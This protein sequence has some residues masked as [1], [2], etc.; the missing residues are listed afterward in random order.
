M[1]YLPGSYGEL[2]DALASDV[3]SSEWHLPYMRYALATSMIIVDER[4]NLNPGRDLT[5]GEI[6]QMMYHAAMYAQGRRTQALLSVADSDIANAATLIEADN[7]EQAE[8][9]TARATVAARGALTQNPEH[10]LVK[11]AVKTAESFRF[12]V[13]AYRAGRE[14]RFDDAITLAGDA[15]NAAA[16]ISELAPSLSDM[17]SQ[18]QLLAKQLADSARAAKG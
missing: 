17:A 12:L 11:G 4:G 5:R 9:A 3:S 1:G 2:T 14:Q 10:A 8:F 6:A 7:I 13:R 18:I 16:R 15:W